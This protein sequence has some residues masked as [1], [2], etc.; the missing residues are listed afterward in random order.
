MSRVATA[1]D[2]Q[3]LQPTPTL[4]PLVVQLGAET[5]DA[6]AAAVADRVVSQLPEARERH[7]DDDTIF[8][9][10]EAADYLRLPSVNALHK[11]TARGE[12]RSEDRGVRGARLRIRKSWCDDW[13]E[14][15]Q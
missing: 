5:I 9:S 13:L 4:P 3:P 8:N 15:S 1:T 11:L 10:R 14:G 2:T 12:L 7:L 6:L